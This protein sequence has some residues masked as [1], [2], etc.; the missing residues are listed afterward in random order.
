MEKKQKRG[1]AL[2]GHALYRMTFTAMWR[3]KKSSLLL[4]AVSAVSVFLS[5]F[6]QNLITRQEAA[7]ETM[8]HDTAIQCIVTDA[9]GNN[10]DSLRMPHGFVDRLLGR[11]HEQ[12]CFLDESVKNVRAKASMKLETPQDTT[13]RR[14]LSIASDPA[15]SKAEG[16]EVQMLPGWTEN[17]LQTDQ[18]VCL[19]PEGMEPLTDEDGSSYV[20]VSM[21]DGVELKLQVVGIVRGGAANVIWCPFYMQRLDDAQELV[22]VDSCSFDL[23]DNTKIEECKADIYEE[24]VEPNLGNTPD[25]Y[26]FGVLV[27]DE[28]YQNT[29]KELRSNVSMLRLLLPV[30]TVLCIGIG[31]LAGYL[32]T[33]GRIREFAVMRCLGMKQRTVFVQIFA[34]YVCLSALGT[35]LGGAAGFWIERTLSVDAVGKAALL[36]AC[37]L[38]GTAVSVWNVTHVNTMK[39]M[40]AE[41]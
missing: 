23:A 37:F 10:T 25:I 8:V 5:V 24:F 28:T 40:K 31:F 3:R 35:V 29:L 21:E 16:S 36:V 15:L 2:R 18:R 14:I 22:W 34:E 4:L 27:Q 12:G 39:L 11:R 33:R 26:T 7:I 17:V 30:L 9:R 41:E 19:I 20:N 38:I 6:L 1:R 32:T 13:M